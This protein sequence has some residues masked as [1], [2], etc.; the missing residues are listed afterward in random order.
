MANSG[1]LRK[2]MKREAD[3][4]P[5]TSEFELA[6]FRFYSESVRKKSV[7]LIR[8]GKLRVAEDK[9]PLGLH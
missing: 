2:K 6:L 9:K 5:A 3:R 7:K 8:E 4:E 1:Y